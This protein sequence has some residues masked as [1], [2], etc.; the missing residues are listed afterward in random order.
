MMF[1]EFGDKEL[2]TIILLH[3]G[4]LSYW[5]LLSIV[6]GMKEDYHVVTPIIEGH[7]DNGNET[8]I[9]I[10]Q[11]ADNLLA[12]IDRVCNGKVFLLG[13]LSLGAQIVIEVLSRRD[14]VSQYA[15]LESP[16]VIPI[17]G[18]TTLTVPMFKLFYGLV[19]VKWFSKKQG[20]A[21][22]VPENMFERYY[23]DSQKITK[24]SLINITLSNGNYVLKRD[25][26]NTKAKVMIIVGDKER[27]IM[28]K[29][30]QTLNSKIPN[31]KLY[32]A[33]K[34]KHGEL[35]LAYPTEYIRTIEEF[36]S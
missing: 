30:A 16:L 12:Y 4:G 28:K 34:M 33:K 3:G 19:K 8:F 35:S 21:L 25:I 7:G 15:I 11:S 31:S 17:K 22:F 24:Q 14:N 23:Y 1:M 9:S 5:S 13:G 26:E 2:P 6:E 32:I 27:G 10:E 29:S 36:I 18:L 20:K